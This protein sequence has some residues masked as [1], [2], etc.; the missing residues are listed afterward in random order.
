M[1]SEDRKPNIHF[2]ATHWGFDEIPLTEFIPR[3]RQ[4]GY[5]ET[6]MGRRRYIPEVRSSNPNIRA[7]GD[8]MAVNMPIQGTS[9]D[10]IKIAMVR[11]Q[12]QM[13]ALKLRSLM[14]IQVHDELIFEVPQDEL[15]QM[16]GLVEELMPSAMDLAVPLDVEFK[17]GETWGDME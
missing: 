2:F 9:A 6:V 13:D 16:R 8:R 10:I 7:A 5:V 15:E 3:V 17:V 14:I 12:R 4:S 11:I 1:K